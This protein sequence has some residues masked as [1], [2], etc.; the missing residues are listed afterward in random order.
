MRS[1]RAKI[2]ERLRGKL[3]NAA[4]VS[5]S[6]THTVNMTLNGAQSMCYNS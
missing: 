6:I 1:G 2:D 5:M 3:K 4:I